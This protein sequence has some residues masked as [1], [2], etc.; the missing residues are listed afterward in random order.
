MLRTYDCIRSIPDPSLPR[1]AAPPF[2]MDMLPPSVD[3][4]RF[5]P[6]IYDQG[7][8]GSCAGNGWARVV[9]Q[10]RHYAKLPDWVPSRLFIYYCARMIE[11][12][13]QQ[14]NGVS[15]TD[16]AKALATYG[17]PPESEW[18]YDVSRFAVQP[19]AKAIADAKPHKILDPQHLDNSDL[20]TLKGCLAVGL[21]FTFG[22]TVFESFESQQVASTGVMP[23]PSP[24]ERQ[25]GGHCVTAEGFS[26]DKQAF[27]CANSWSADWGI[28]GY[29]WMSYQFITNLDLASD[30]WTASKVTG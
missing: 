19:S 18:P 22:F 6:P 12:T 10:I 15:I 5:A 2:Q 27:L 30:C 23:M 14:D 17:A 1:F 28:G 29:F 20:H 13:I 21:P 24:G 16:G 4:R 25:L 3:L 11:G 26:D 8:L 7:A 9:Q